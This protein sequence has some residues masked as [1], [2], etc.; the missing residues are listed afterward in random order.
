MAGTDPP[1]SEPTPRSCT[2][3]PVVRLDARDNV[4]VATRVLRR[5][6]TID[7]GGVPIRPR[8]DIP[9]GHK[10]AVES[11]AD[12]KPVTKYGQPIGVAAGEIEPGDHVHSHNLVDQ[13]IVSNDLSSI[14]P[15]DP[16]PG[17]SRSFHG[18]HRSDGRVGTRNYVAIIST[19]NCSATVCH[20]VVSRFDQQRMKR[21]PNVDG[22]FAATHTTWMRPRVPRDQAP[23]AGPCSGGIRESAQRRRLL[24]HW[25]RL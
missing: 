4:A 9:A 7:V 6:E 24:D 23:D 8:C 22:V 10:I 5:G 25:T 18:F 11:I 17:L 13:H 16:P 19:V 3:I 14:R 15:P 12:S 2:S 20:Q 1:P 21:W